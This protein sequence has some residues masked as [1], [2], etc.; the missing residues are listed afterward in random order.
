MSRC[1]LDDK[2]RGTEV[3]IGWDPPLRTFFARVRERIVHDTEA[4]LGVEDPGVRF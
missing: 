2:T 1:V 3:V 4:V